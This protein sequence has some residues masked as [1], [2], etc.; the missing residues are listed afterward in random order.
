MF[1]ELAQCANPNKVVF[2]SVSEGPFGGGGTQASR[3]H[4]V[5]RS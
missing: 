4:W 2:P 3:Y 1:L 5:K